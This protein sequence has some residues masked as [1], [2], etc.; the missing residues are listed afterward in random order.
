MKPNRRELAEA[1]RM[2]VGSL[3]ETTAAARSLIEKHGFSAI[4]V[5]LSEDGM[6][7]VEADGTVHTLPAV[8]REV[9]DVSGAG[10]TVVATLAVALGAGLALPDAARVANAAAGIVVGKIG[11]AIVHIDELTDALGRADGRPPSKIQPLPPVLDRIATWRQQ[12]FKI[13]FTN[14]CFDILHPGH[15]ALLEQARDACDRLVV[16]LNSDASVRRLKGAGR[17]V[18]AELSRA[19][20]LASLA[21]VDL[22]TVFE[23]DTP[24]ALITAI[25]PDVLVKGADYRVEEVVGAEIVQSYGGRVLLAELKPGHSTTATIRKMGT[26]G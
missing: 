4:L 26:A 22:V 20:V 6:M 5:S 17:P 12:G 23:E 16:G 10:D 18:Q 3:A 21:S 8:A 2:P 15:V 13:G 25:R 11:T 14:G 9:F 24:E 7:L 1:T 19:Q